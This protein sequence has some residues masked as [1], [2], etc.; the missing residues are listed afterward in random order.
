MIR[1]RR[2]ATRVAATLAALLTLASCSPINALSGVIPGGTYEL[3]ADVS[4]GPLARHKLDVYR[5]ISTPP[6]AG[7]PVVVFFY[8]GSWNR[9][10]RRE[11]KFTGEA[12][13]S[14]GGL[15]SWPTTASIAKYAGPTS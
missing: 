13:A 8:A 12:L 10:E 11:H 4:Y 6:A 14:R 7:W 5:P 1:S 2:L 3:S 9:G 15:T